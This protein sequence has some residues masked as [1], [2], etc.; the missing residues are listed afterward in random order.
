MIGKIFLI[1]SL[2][3]IAFGISFKI[4]DFL[5]ISSLIL[6]FSIIDYLSIRKPRFYL[7]PL[8]NYLEMKRGEEYS[9][10]LHIEG[11]RKGEELIP[12]F[13][14][15]KINEDNSKNSFIMIIKPNKSGI[16]ELNSLKVKK[17]SFLFEKTFLVNVNPPVKFSVYPKSLTKIREFLSL[18]IG[19][20]N[21][22]NITGLGEE[23]AYTDE[24]RSG[25]DTR[26]IDWK[27]TAKTGKIMVKKFYWDLYGGS[28][29]IIDLESTDEN[30]ADDIATEALNALRFSYYMNSKVYIYDGEKI[31]S[32]NKN[33]Y[34]ALLLILDMLK[35]YYPE[36]NRLLDYYKKKTEKI[37]ENI[38][39]LDYMRSGDTKVII[40]S[41][42]LSDLI[43]KI[44]ELF[45]E[46]VM[47]IIIQP[48]KPW[49]YIDDIEVSYNIRKRY[50][51]N[52]E[53]AKN[54]GF[55]IFKSFNEIGGLNE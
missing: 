53:Y 36:Y 28:S 49:I 7:K 43:F 9:L 12:P 48:S 5:V 17:K 51:I 29:I 31:K 41:Q 35:K 21:P 24:L 34:N 30:S 18:G 55:E 38:K 46:K 23:Y 40:V 14:F 50:E 42:L 10:I 39:D 54:N 4:I 15:C 16:Y 8:I 32:V 44:K 6:T 2:F 25:D 33:I 20:T 19:Y 47:G 13:S 22:S 45:N 1:F 26:R 52:Y 37:K 3:L 27:K 11:D